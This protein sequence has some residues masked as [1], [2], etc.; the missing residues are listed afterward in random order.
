MLRA[1]WK[2]LTLDYKFQEAW[3]YKCNELIFAEIIHFVT[4]EA[5]TSQDEAPDL[6]GYKLKEGK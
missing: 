1:Y 2:V 3:P 5:I 4:I 6:H